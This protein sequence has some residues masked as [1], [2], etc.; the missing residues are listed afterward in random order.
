MSLFGEALFKQAVAQGQ[1][2][3]H[4]RRHH[5]G[6]PLAAHEQAFRG[7]PAGALSLAA[8]AQ[9]RRPTCSTST[10]RI[11]TSSAPR[12]KSSCASRAIRKADHGAADRRHAQA[13][14]FASTRTRRSPPSSSPTR[15]S[16]PNMYPVARPR[17]QRRRSRGENRQRQADREHDRSSAT[18]TS[19]TSFPTSRQAAARPQCARRA[20]GDLPRRHRFRCAE[21]AGDG[22]HRRARTRQ[23]RHLCRCR[24]L[25]RLPWRHG[26]GHRHPHGGRQGRPSCMC[27]P[28]PVSLPIPTRRP[29]GRKRRTRRV[30]SCAR[31]SSPSRAS[32]HDS[33]ER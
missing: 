3:H 28:A 23:A 25:P 9:S 6:R 12:R 31:R 33:N 27:R 4:R 14:R 2:P 8:L 5:A 21:S 17:A 13:R 19:C 20:Q 26:L 16:A 30:P 15:R 10:S 7:E 22:D 1:A 18:P 11:S 29:N 24:R 32:I